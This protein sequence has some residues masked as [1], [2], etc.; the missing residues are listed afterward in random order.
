MKG[1]IECCSWLFFLSFFFFFGGRGWGLGCAIR[2]MLYWNCVSFPGEQKL[3]TFLSLFVNQMWF[4]VGAPILF[5]NSVVF[6]SFPVLSSQA[7]LMSTKLSYVLDY[8]LMWS[9]FYLTGC[10]LKCND[11][12]SSAECEGNARLW[13]YNIFLLFT[14][15]FSIPFL[16]LRSGDHFSG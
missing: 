8:S 9:K 3:K 11:F 13:A 5:P 15:F 10:Q 14:K 12:E 16:F 7:I 2:Q 1:I 4:R 6:D